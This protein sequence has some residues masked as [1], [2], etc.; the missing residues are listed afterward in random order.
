MTI[1]WR[2]AWDVKM[3]FL[4][5]ADMLRSLNDY[6]H[7]V[8]EAVYEEVRSLPGYPRDYDPDHDEIQI[9]MTTLRRT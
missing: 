3:R 8:R 5:L 9:V 6:D 1:E 4:E 2:C 7:D